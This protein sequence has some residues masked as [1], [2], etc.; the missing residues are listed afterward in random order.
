MATK[1]MD[2]V[3]FCKKVEANQRVCKVLHAVDT[4]L[5]ESYASVMLDLFRETIRQ[6]RKNDSQFQSL[7][8][9]YGGVARSAMRY[10]DA[11]GVTAAIAEAAAP[12]VDV[13]YVHNACV[14]AYEVSYLHN[15]G[16][17]YEKI[18]PFWR[19]V[20]EHKADVIGLMREPGFTLES[21]VEPA[22]QSFGTEKHGEEWEHLSPGLWRRMAGFGLAIVNCVA[23]VPTAGIAVASVLAGAAGVAAG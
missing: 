8:Q 4:H 16:V 11:S 14:L 1:Q 19:F 17:P 15:M 7:K 20:D 9:A 13:S 18:A 6:E 10:L 21:L 23:T 3:A 5:C 2:L 22:V 12:L